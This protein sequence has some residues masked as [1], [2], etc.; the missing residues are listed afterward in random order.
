MSRSQALVLAGAVSALFAAGCAHCD[1]CDDFPI[2]QN[3]P[4]LGSYADAV[5]T[6]APGQ[7][8]TSVPAQPGSTAP[9]PTTESPFRSDAATPAP[10]SDATPPALESVPGRPAEPPSSPPDPGSANPAA[11]SPASPT[12]L[13]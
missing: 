1:S 5:P 11:T 4:A 10:E 3:S 7:I 9:L 6:L 2:T 13:R 12:A 8:V